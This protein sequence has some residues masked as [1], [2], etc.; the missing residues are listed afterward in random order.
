[1]HSRLVSRESGSIGGSVRVAW[2]A[3][4]IIYRRC[5]RT[6]FTLWLAANYAQAL[7]TSKKPWKNA[8]YAGFTPALSLVCL[9]TSTVPASVNGF[10]VDVEYEFCYWP[11]IWLCLDYFLDGTYRV[12]PTVFQVVAMVLFV[13]GA[14][15]YLEAE[16]FLSGLSLAKLLSST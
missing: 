7:L 8:W 6:I 2:H 15:R 11:L 13:F 3:V 1:M 10:A 14:H 16:A 9:Y 12:L 4:C 5:T